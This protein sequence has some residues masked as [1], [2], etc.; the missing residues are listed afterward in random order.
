M[1]QT[2]LKKFSFSIFMLLFILTLAACDPAEE[3]P[4]DPIDPVDPVT[5]VVTFETNG[6]GVVAS[7][8]I[9][10][11]ETATQPQQPVK[12]GFD[13]VHWYVSDEN[14]AFDFSTA[15]T[16]DLTLFALWEEEVPV[17]PTEEELIMLDIEAFDNYDGLIV[18]SSHLELPTRGENGTVLSWSTSDPTAITRKGIVVPNPIGGED[19]QVTLTLNTRNGDTRLTF[20]YDLVVKAK[21][22]SVI[23]SEV[24]LP[25]ESTTNEYVVESGTLLTYYVDE[26]HVP[27]V[28]LEAYM[29]LLDGFVYSDEIEYLFDAETQI[30]TMTYDVTYDND[31]EDPEDDE[32]YTYTA[33]LDFEQNTITVED[34]A[35][36]SGYVQST[37]TDYS[38]GL[39]YLDEMYIE[40]GDQVVFDLDAY[41]FDMIYDEGAYVMPVH[42][43]NLLF[44]GSSYYNVYY[45]V[46]GYKGIY[47]FGEE[48]ETFRTSIANDT[49]P[50][51]DVQLATF[52]AFAFT[53]DYLYGL[54]KINSIETY[55]DQLYENIDG[56]LG[57]A[58]LF[59]NKAYSDFVLKNLDELHSSMIYTTVYDDVEGDTPSLSL[60]DLGPR[61]KSWYDVYYGVQDEFDLRWPDG[62]VPPY[63][64]I[65]D[66][67]IIYLDG[68][69]TKSVDDDESV[70]DSDDYMRD[71]IEDMFIENPN[72][73]NIVVDL[74]YNTGGNIGALYRVLGYVTENPIEVNYQDPLTNEKQT[75][76]VEVATNAV[77]NVDWYFLTSKVTFS[78]AN[79]MAAIGKYQDIATIIGSTSGGGASSIIPVILPDGSMYQLSSLNVLS[80]REGSDVDG[81][82]YND[83]EYGVEPDYFLP[84]SEL[85]NDQ[86][87]LDL[88]NAIKDG[89]ATPYTSS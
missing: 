4:V 19:K 47:A 22:E 60:F 78:A 3:D 25:F 77:Q 70:V 42:I 66:T 61:V 31:T 16:E 23:T 58:P 26:G 88:I 68:F 18:T 63:R 89:T 62:D 15:I 29:N 17:G 64:I 49:T 73:E 33:L 27:Y 54:K 10:E 53:L 86:A 74:S 39:T 71:A 38:E 20:T 69:V 1:S 24:E 85:Y 21:T 5:Y 12:E 81:W 82:V 55:Y 14:V 72:I 37:G 56:F 45:H 36:F 32:T 84:V 67:A 30:L 7:Q 34:M 52:D 65:E 51:A 79:L 75:Y 57:N 35:F 8:T 76:W 46:D 2:F 50:P 59:I 41:R 13:F 9:E 43:I 48:P 28:N 6:G 40:E 11:N 87:I 83:I 80:Y 44:V